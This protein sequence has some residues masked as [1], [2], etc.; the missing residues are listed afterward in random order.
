MQTKEMFCNKTKQ[1]NGMTVEDKR[2]GEGGGVMM[3]MMM[4]SARILTVF[5]GYMLNNGKSKDVAQTIALK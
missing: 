3:V 4:Q 1:Q 5:I 2:V